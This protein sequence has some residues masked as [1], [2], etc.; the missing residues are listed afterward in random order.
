MNLFSSFFNFSICH[1][2][3]LLLLLQPFRNNC[4]P[5]GFPYFSSFLSFIFIVLSL[6]SST[7]K[8]QCSS[9][10]ISLQFLLNLL[11]LL[12]AYSFLLHRVLFSFDVL[13]IS[14]ISSSLLCVLSSSVSNS[15]FTL[16]YSLYSSVLFAFVILFT[17]HVL[18]FPRFIQGADDKL[19]QTLWK[20][21]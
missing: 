13:I 6:I 2:Y 12:L 19:G 10:L 20:P 7:S 16:Q 3:L 1:G 17:L 14:W 9:S 5:W 8:P 11:P 4:H 21:F 18:L 15:L